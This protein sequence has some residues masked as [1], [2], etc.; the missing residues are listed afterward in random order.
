MTLGRFDQALHEARVA[1]ELDPLSLNWDVYIG[2]ILLMSREYDQAIEQLNQAIDVEHN[3]LRA[4]QYLGEAYAAKGM[5][6]QGLQQYSYAS[7]FLNIALQEELSEG[8]ESGV[9]SGDEIALL[10]RAA[11]VYGLS[12]DGDR[13]RRILNRVVQ[14]TQ[15]DYFTPMLVAKAYIGLGDYDKAFTLLERAYE[16]RVP[17]IIGLDVFPGYDALKSDPRFDNL[18]SRIRVA[19]Q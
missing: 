13:A 12:G 14:S 1:K 7:D 19:L 10:A 6:S 15:N 5:Y 17:A 9:L 2:L 4:R 16:A 3:L 11:Y 8:A 18:R